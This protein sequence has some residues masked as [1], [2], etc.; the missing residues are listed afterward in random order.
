M[1]R[2]YETEK[3][4]TLRNLNKAT[5]IFSRSFPIIGE[6]ILYFRPLDN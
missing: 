6:P 2:K 3:C 4:K 5:I 1:K